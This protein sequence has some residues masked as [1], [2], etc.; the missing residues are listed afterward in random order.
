[1]LDHRLPQTFGLFSH[2]ASQSPG[3]R[4]TQGQQFGE[5]RLPVGRVGGLVLSGKV[6]NLFGGIG[7]DAQAE[8]SQNLF[9]SALDFHIIAFGGLFQG[10]F[11]CQACLPEPFAGFFT[12]FK[13]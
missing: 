8:S 3:A 7:V 2:Q 9:D 13:V 4:R 1:M 11:G 10:G 5:D 12:R 6:D